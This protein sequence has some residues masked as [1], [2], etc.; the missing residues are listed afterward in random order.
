MPPVSTPPCKPSVTTVTAGKPHKERLHSAEGDQRT[1]IR[2]V[3]SFVLTLR[4]WEQRTPVSV[5]PWG[6]ASAEQVISETS[7]YRGGRKKMEKNR[8]AAKV[9]K[10]KGDRRA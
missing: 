7:F 10:K 4:N 6:L 9:T 8:I 2:L 3:Q 5:C 1:S